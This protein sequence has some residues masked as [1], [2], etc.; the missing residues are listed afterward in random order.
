MS[1]TWASVRLPEKRGMLAGPVRMAS[2]TCCAVME[3]FCSDGA[4]VPKARASPAPVM[5]WQAAQFSEKRSAPTDWFAPCRCGK[6]TAG[7]DGVERVDPGGDLERLLGRQA[8]LAALGL[9]RLD[10]G[11]RHAAR[12]DPEVDRRR[13]DALQVRP[14]GGLTLGVHAVGRRAV[15]ARAELGEE[16]LPGR[17][18][19]PRRVGVGD[20]AVAV[21]HQVP[22]DADAGS[23]W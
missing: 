1:R 18:V 5:V 23:C 21:A 10:V 22:V 14:D 11:G 12:A 16:L 2:A 13:A 6:G 17:D 19:G 7:T 9:H 20:G 3:R 4:L 8:G 15:A